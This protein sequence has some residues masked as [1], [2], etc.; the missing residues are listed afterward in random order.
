MMDKIRYIEYINDRYYK[1]YITNDA[2]E[3]RNSVC[4]KV[5]IQADI[6][7]EIISAEDSYSLAE[8]IEYFYYFSR[9]ELALEAIDEILRIVKDR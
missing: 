2:K 1:F 3:K 7:P 8:D 4:L 9:I 5:V 6:M